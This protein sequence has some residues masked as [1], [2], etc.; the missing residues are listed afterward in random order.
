MRRVYLDACI[1]MGNRGPSPVVVSGGS[2]LGGSKLHS[3]F[4]S[5]K[6][7]AKS[8]AVVGGF[9][10]V[11]LIVILIIVGVLAVAAIPR[12][13][14][15]AD[16]DARGFI[17]ATLSALHYAQKS[18]IAQRREV[19]V[20]FSPGGTTM[21]LT[22]AA[23]FSSVPTGC[24]GN[25]LTGPNG[26]SPY[27]VTARGATTFAPVPAGFSFMPSGRATSGQAI[28]VAGYSD[29]TITVD[30]ATGYAYAP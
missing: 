2:P 4:L 13:Y 17:D 3:D 10:L 11:E 21:T 18:A 29:K 5:Y 19:C 6:S 9:T 12:F 1:V 8:Y 15:R 25:P 7:L 14:D 16:Y 24:A 23:G 30:A 26:T 22:I 20:A 28:S 27:V